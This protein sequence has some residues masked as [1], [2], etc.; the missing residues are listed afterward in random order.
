M[1]YATSAPASI[2]A[3]IFGNKSGWILQIGVNQELSLP[4]R[5]AQTG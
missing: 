1:A 3:I 5:Y 2:A 4:L